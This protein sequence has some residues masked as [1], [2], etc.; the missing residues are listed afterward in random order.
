M[1]VNFKEELK[2]KLVF[3][4]LLK[5]RDLL[6]RMLLLKKQEIRFT[7]CSFRK[8]CRSSKMKEIQQGKLKISANLQFLSVPCLLPRS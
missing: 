6:I 5:N 1:N 2:R 8:R 4:N 3:N 7:K